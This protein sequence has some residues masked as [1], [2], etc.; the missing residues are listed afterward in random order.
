MAYFRLVELPHRFVKNGLM[1]IHGLVSQ[2]GELCITLSKV[3]PENFTATQAP[4]RER[5]WIPER[6][7][8]ISIKRL[9]LSLT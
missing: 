7:N 9:C 1:L 8:T 4:K 5:M 3:Q 2:A 6:G